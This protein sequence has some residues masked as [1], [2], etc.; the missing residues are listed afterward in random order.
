MD[1]ASK[2]LEETTDELKNY[3]NDFESFQSKATE[4]AKKY[5]IDPTFPEKRQRKT[6]KH[7]DELA[8]DYRF[9]N[10]EEIFNCVLDII[11]NQID[12]RFSGT[13][14]KRFS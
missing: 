9:Q 10:H 2:A 8:S 7:F 1:E 6:K 4:T 13:S 14:A 3:R 12:A 5:D 11:I